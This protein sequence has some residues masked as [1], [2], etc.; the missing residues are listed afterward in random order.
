MPPQSWGAL[1][2]REYTRTVGRGNRWRDGLPLK[3]RSTI[4]RDT[5]DL[6]TKQGANVLVT[7]EAPSVHH[8]GFELVDELARQMQA[9][10]TFHGHHHDSMDY[11]SQWSQLGHKAY[12]VG[13]CGITTLD[14]TVIRIGNF[15]TVRKTR[16]DYGLQFKSIVED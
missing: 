4:F 10:T 9:N 13:F 15:E 8:H 6:L 7:H 3:H 12:G 11:S 16:S 14:G 2:A 1:S 5:Y